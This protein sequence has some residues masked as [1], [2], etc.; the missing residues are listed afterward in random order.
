MHN[1]ASKLV[2]LG[3]PTP[4]GSANSR[5]VPLQIPR[6]RPLLPPV[7]PVPEVALGI[8]QLIQTTLH[9]ATLPVAVVSHLVAVAHKLPLLVTAQLPARQVVGTV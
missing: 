8:P 1:V 3:L 7:V 4:L 9:R 6:L 2:V 5:E